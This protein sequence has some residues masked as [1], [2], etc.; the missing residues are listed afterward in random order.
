MLYAALLSNVP[1]TIYPAGVNIAAQA[2]YILANPLRYLLTAAVDGYQNLFY[3]NASGLFGWLDAD[4]R[5]TDLLVP[6]LFLA[7][8][9]LYG[10]DAAGRKKGD[11]WLSAGLSLLLYGLVVTGFYCTWSTLGSTSIL[12]VQARY[13]LPA[14]P[15]VFLLVSSACGR[16]V[17]FTAPAGAKDAAAARD[18]LCIF[19]CFGAAVLAAAELSLVYYFT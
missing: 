10:G 2:R 16:A 9:G 4:A 17:R 15:L 3:W 14:V 19:L 5:L 11:L 7:C 1:P 13:F 8:C 12:G 6:V 18:A